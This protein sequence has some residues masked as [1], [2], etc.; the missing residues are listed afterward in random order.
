VY[1]IELE[2]EL[3][4]FLGTGEKLVWTGKPKEGVRLRAADTVLIP[5]SLLWGGFAIFWE[6]T[7]ITTRAP[8][9]FKLFGIP[10][11]LVGLYMIFGR[12]IVDAVRRKK[13]VYG[14]TGDRVIIKSGIL[15]PTIKSLN[16]RTI[17]DISF[18][19]KNDGSGTIILGPTVPVAD[20]M[21]GFSWTG[22]SAVPELELI[23]DVKMVYDKLINI[24]RQAG[25]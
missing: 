21:R 8:L 17:S 24:Q 11:V 2:N 14:I 6:S 1:D 12:F 13:T 15:T 23:A 5:F 3:R 4:P 19:Q 22:G 18:I 7:V 25:E 10:F 9:L 20:K 16:I